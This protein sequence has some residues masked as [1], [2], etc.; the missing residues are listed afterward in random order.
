MLYPKPQKLACLAVVTVWTVLTTLQTARRQPKR[1][2]A[3]NSAEEMA[4]LSTVRGDLSRRLSSQRGKYQHFV[5]LTTQRSGSTYFMS[6]FRSI[7]QNG[8][9][10][11]TVISEPV[12][13]L[14]REKQ[15]TFSEISAMQWSDF[16][17]VLRD[18]FAKFRCDLPAEAPKQPSDMACG[19]KLMYNQIPGSRNVPTNMSRKM[20]TWLVSGNVKIVHLVR[21]SHVRKVLSIFRLAQTGVAHMRK[22]GELRPEFSPLDVDAR[23]LVGA[24]KESLRVSVSHRVD[25][26]AVVP[27]GYL[28]EVFYEDLLADSVRNSAATF[29]DVLGFVSPAQE[30]LRGYIDRVT[31]DLVRNPVLPCAKLVSDWASIEPELFALNATK[32]DEKPRLDDEMHAELDFALQDCRTASYDYPGLTV[33]SPLSTVRSRLRE[34]FG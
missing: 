23:R 30:D 1:A 15:L 8:G 5:V 33:P 34:F 27:A 3:E 31:T 9:P 6:L 32:L 10:M 14:L 11:R 26:R 19:F 24:V 28:H 12:G 13:Q 4:S 7:Q 16:E 25:L 21:R 22:G 20:C 17:R 2:A 29:S 18:A